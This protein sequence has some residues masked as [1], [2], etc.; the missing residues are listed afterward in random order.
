MK[1]I[2]V[3]K[4][5]P[6]YTYRSTIS[7]DPIPN[8]IVKEMVYNEDENITYVRLK[9]KTIWIEFLCSIIII[10][11][12]TLSII[13]YNNISVKCNYNS[14][15]NYYDNKLF[16]NWQNPSENT[17]DITFELVDG[18]DVIY[19]ITLTPGESKTYIDLDSVATK[20]TCTMSIN[21]FNKTVTEN[22][23]LTVINRELK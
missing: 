10:C 6:I 12:V 1:K 15:V 21:L 2:K 5:T 4:G 22:A 23:T 9:R 7:L 17:I 13:N 14:L 20:Y 11:C 18:K 16:L 8:L 3:I 19:K